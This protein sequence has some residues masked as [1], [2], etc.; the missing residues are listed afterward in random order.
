MN[1]ERIERELSEL[2]AGGQLALLMTDGR[3]AVLYRDVPTGGAQFGL[4]ISS[5][6]VV[7]IPDGYP[8]NPIDLAGLPLGS[9]LLARVKGGANSQGV[10]VANGSQFQL[11]SYHPHNNG[12]GPPWDQTRHGFHTYFDHILA[13]L[14]RLN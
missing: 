2:L 13:W 3:P 7:P 12:G 14:H 6:V 5:D 11:A 1:R 8:A 4:P 9:P 10:I